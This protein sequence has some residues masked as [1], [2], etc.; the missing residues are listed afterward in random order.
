M[1]IKLKNLSEQE[2]KTQETK[3]RKVIAGGKTYKYKG[4]KN[5]MQRQIEEIALGIEEV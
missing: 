4:P 3:I 1:T 5:K 2:T